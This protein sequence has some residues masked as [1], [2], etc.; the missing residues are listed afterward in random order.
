MILSDEDSIRDVI[1]FPKNQR[2]VDLMFQAPA[3]VALDQLD[4]LGL[5]VQKVKLEETEAS[6]AAAEEI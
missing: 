1:A 4:E 5:E 2:G 3:A 6:L